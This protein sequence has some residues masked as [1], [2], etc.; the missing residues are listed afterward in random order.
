MKKTSCY[1]KKQVGTIMKTI[2]AETN[3]GL[4]RKNN[5]DVALAITHPK[6]ENIHLLLVADGMGGKEHGEIA[7]SYTAK[8]FEKWFKSRSPKVLNDCEKVEDQIIELVDQINEAIIKKM[9]QNITGTTLSLALVNR[10]G[11]VIANSGDSRIYIYKNK[12]LIQLSEDD[13]DVWCYY[14]YGM[15]RKDDLRFFY[16]NNIITACIGLANDICT[17]Q[18]EIIENNY[19]SI[20]VLTD[21]VTDLITDR[22]IKKIM[23]SNRNKDVLSKIIHEAVY[24]EQNLKI[25]L[26]LKHKKLSKYILPFHGRDNASGAIYIK[27]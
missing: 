24:V 3:I 8:T 14:K 4:V 10:S 7:S 26:R 1:N 12:K 23:E 2:Q 17:V 11:T 15:V 6:D 27:R 18:T 16:N 22:K 5:E 20:L 19:D 21:G 25:P 9:G 13:S